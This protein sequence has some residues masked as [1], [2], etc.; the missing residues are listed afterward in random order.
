MYEAVVE[1]IQEGQ[2][3]A[4]AE[5]YEESYEEGRKEGLEEERKYFLGLLDQGLSVEEIKQCLERKR[6]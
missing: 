3:E 2:Q 4:W 1:S 6:P 5:D